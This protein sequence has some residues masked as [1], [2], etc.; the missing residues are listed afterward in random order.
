MKVKKKTKNCWKKNKIYWFMYANYK[1][2]YNIVYKKK[3][4]LDKKLLFS[5][6][7]FE[8]RSDIYSY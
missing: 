3:S 5:L 6:F 7:S 1:I 8:A 4:K 2:L